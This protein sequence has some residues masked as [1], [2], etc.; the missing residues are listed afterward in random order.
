MQQ[1]QAVAIKALQHHPSRLIEPATR[2]QTRLQVGFYTREQRRHLG[3]DVQPGAPVRIA[4]GDIHDLVQGED[5]QALEAFPRAF[6]SGLVEPAAGIQ[7]LEFGQGEGTD[8]AVLALG[9]ALGNI[10]GALQ[11]IVVHCYQY[12]VF[13][14][15]QVQLEVIGPQVAGQQVGRGSGLRGIVGCT[16]MSDYG[17]V[18]DLLRGRQFPALSGLDQ[19]G[20]R[21]QK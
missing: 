6:G 21:Q 16:A 11:V 10:A 15:L 19:S 5:L 9:K 17:R 14:A 7:R 18:R 20:Q 1:R 12:A 4:F 3:L 2:L 8:R 13:T